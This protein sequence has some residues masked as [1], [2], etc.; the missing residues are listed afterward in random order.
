MMRIAVHTD[1][2]YFRYEIASRRLLIHIG[3]IQGYKLCPF[4]RT[5]YILKS[6]TNTKG[7]YRL[8]DTHVRIDA[9]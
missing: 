2:E 1:L 8:G 3:P 5:L 9:I 4:I 6:L 7:C